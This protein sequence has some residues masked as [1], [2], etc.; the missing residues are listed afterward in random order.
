MSSLP[1][2]REAPVSG[3]PV[4]DALQHGVQLEFA[5]PS[6]VY[7]GIK[8]G[9]DMVLAILLLIPALPIIG[10][11]WVLV[12]L[13]SSGPGFY[14]QTRSGKD[15]APYRI[16]KLR[17]MAHD[18]EARTGIQ[19]SQKGDSRVTKL[20]KF[21]RTT[22]LDELP[23]LFNVIRG[24]MSLVGPR[25]ERP[26]VINS[27]GLKGLVT[28]YAERLTVRPGVTGLA[29][30]QLPADSDIASVRHKVVYDLYYVVNQS[31]WLDLRLIVATLFKAMGFGPSWLRRLFFFPTRDEVA[32]EFLRLMSPPPN[33]G[34][35]RFQAA[36]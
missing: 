15:G 8:P 25:P 6:S 16:I 21:L 20:G 28:G 30:L 31:L 24:E 12:K 33:P 5:P 35:A 27:K 11:C 1:T 34:S 3:W 22:H 9:I 4:I 18:C 2:S 23:Q 26:E 13:S 7:A 29:Q 36:T 19:W 32:E 17:T 14:I 10:I